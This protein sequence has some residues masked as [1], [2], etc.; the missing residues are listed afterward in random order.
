MLSPPAPCRSHR[1]SVDR[2]GEAP[3][4]VLDAL[5]LERSRMK[6]SE[7]LRAR[8]QRSYDSP[9]G[10]GARHGAPRRDPTGFTTMWTRRTRG[11]G[12]G[13]G[14]SSRL[15]NGD[16]R[17]GD[18]RRA[19]PLATAKSLCCEFSDDAARGV[20]RPRR[21]RQ[22]RARGC[23]PRSG[24]EPRCGVLGDVLADARGAVTAPSPRA[25]RIVQR[26]TGAARSGADPRLG[27]QAS[28]V[29]EKMGKSGFMSPAR[30]MKVSNQS[31]NS[32]SSSATRGRR[33]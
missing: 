21:Q 6:E 12:A 28:E 23:A 31:R 14:S 17:L 22:A 30:G 25:A 20:P 7:V 10:C 19:L 4:L 33:R 1:R 26:K 5:A 9:P 8:A 11:N 18:Q 16:D 3:Q 32:T 27:C 24:G 2:R 15:R 29:Q 13:T